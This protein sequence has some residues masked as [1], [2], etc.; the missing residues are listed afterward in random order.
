MKLI[1]KSYP[2]P[3]LITYKQINGATFDDMDQDVK[4]QLKEY[5]LNEQG[6]ICGYCQQKIKNTECM[7]IEHHC[8][9]SICNGVGGTVDRRLDYTNLMAVCMGRSSSGL[10]CDT[11]KANFNTTT[12]L[13]INISPWIIAH[14]NGVKYSSTGLIS[15][16]NRTHDNEI[17]TILNLNTPYLKENRQKIWLQ[18]F[19]LCKGKFGNDFK[20]KIRRLTAPYIS[21]A[22]NQYSSPY[23]GLYQFMSNRFG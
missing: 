5:L 17:N 21:K 12:G 4:S 8:E 18:L 23:P 19:I 7:K 22:G 1:N 11:Q 16:T 15:S 3:L 6:W 9:Q 10:H 20:Q 14:I 13:P 2:P